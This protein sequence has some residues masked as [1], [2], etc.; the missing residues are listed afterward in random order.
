LPRGRQ[1]GRAAGFPGGEKLLPDLTLD[2]PDATSDDDF[3]ILSTIHSA[4]GRSGSAYS[5]SMS[6]MAASRDLAQSLASL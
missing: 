4:K 2:P 5:C 3:L 1:P 6:S